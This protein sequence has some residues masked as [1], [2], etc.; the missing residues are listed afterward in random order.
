MAGILT[1]T[2]IGRMLRARRHTTLLLAIIALFAVRPF[3][4]ESG[5]MPSSSIS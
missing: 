4:G 3:L 1:S 5:A 2:A